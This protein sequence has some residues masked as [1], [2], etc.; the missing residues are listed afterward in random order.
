MTY[1]LLT[2]ALVFDGSSFVYSS[3]NCLHISILLDFL[4]VLYTHLIYH[5][6]IGFVFISMKVDG[7]YS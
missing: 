7:P 6:P 4:P 2:F 1:S 5:P 3:W